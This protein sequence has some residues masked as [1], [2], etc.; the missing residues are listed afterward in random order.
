MGST[1]SRH[2]SPSTSNHHTRRF[3][4][5]LLCGR[6]SPPH[7]DMDDSSHV[8]FVNSAQVL[9]SQSTE[10][11]NQVKESSLNPCVK[12]RLTYLSTDMES[13]SES[14]DPAIRG[15]LSLNLSQGESSSQQNDSHGPS[16]E[17]TMLDLV[18]VG[19]MN[20]MEESSDVNCSARGS[21][22]AALHVQATNSSAR[23]V[24]FDAGGE[25]Q[26]YSYNSG[27][28]TSLSDETLQ[29]TSS[30]LG[31]VVSNREQGQ[32]DASY[33]HVDM[34]SISSDIVSSNEND[35]NS[36]HNVRRNSRRLFWDAFSRRSSRRHMDSPTVHISSSDTDDLGSRG[37]RWLLDFNGD[38][39]DDIGSSS[40]YLGN[41]IHSMNEQRRQS[42]SE[43]LDR[44]RGGSSSYEH[45]RRSTICSTGQH[46]N[47]TCSCDPLINEEST[48]RV[49]ITR[50]VMLAEALFEVLDEIHRQP[51]AFSM[52]MVMV[53]A[54]EDVVNSFP[55]KNHKKHITTDSDDE[56]DQ[57]YICL[58]EYEEGD[59][60]RVLPCRHEYHMSCVDKWLKEIHGVCPLC[61]GD[62]CKAPARPVEIITP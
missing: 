19:V 39:F 30:A 16:V 58:D 38:F 27:L 22:H 31:V 61:R 9:S 28:S 48:T 17:Q 55:L 35:I 7:P 56:V 24:D 36:N 52:S 25:P 11:G 1:T 60:I 50:I 54:P 20:N 26:V 47:G 46:P 23:L 51:L 29:E 41:R 33:L 13:S 5:S 12:S 18:S 14:N 53:P 40:G 49:T 42:R 62:V 21:S 6:S 45:G 15:N 37:G 43:I 34:V 10:A 2:A 8:L 3:F 4:S 57:C 44:L 59:N 32:E